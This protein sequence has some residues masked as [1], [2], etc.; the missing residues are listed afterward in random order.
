MILLYATHNITCA[1]TLTGHNAYYKQPLW[2]TSVFLLSTHRKRWYCSFI[3]IHIWNMCKRNI[4]W[5]FLKHWHKPISLASFHIVFTRGKKCKHQHFRSGF[6]STLA[7]PSFIL[8]HILHKDS[9]FQY[10]L[11]CVSRFYFYIKIF[12]IVLRTATFFSFHPHLNAFFSILKY[13]YNKYIIRY[14]FYNPKPQCHCCCCNARLLNVVDKP[15][16]D[17]VTSRARIFHRYL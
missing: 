5:G 12:L 16:C 3:L 9:W 15:L 6:F 8:F 14:V 4:C 13:L 11:S 2:H 7:F 17:R 10:Y 1:S